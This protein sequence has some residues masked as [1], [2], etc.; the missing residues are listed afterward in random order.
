M[1]LANES[2]GSSDQRSARLPI[3]GTGLEGYIGL[4]WSFVLEKLN[5]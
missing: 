2:R 3:L 1:L 4:C 5:G